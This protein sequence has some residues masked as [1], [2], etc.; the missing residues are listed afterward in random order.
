MSLALA[1][2]RRTLALGSTA[3]AALAATA[4]LAYTPAD[5]L[6]SP[7]NAR[8]H[9]LLQ[10][11]ALDQDLARLSDLKNLAS[12]QSLKREELLPKYQE[13]VQRYCE[14]GLNFPNRVAVQVMVWLFDTGQFEDALELADFL[15]EQG[16][17]MPERFKRRDIQTFVADA[18][19]EWAYAEYNAKRSPEPYLSDLLPRVDG[20]WNLT[21]QIPSKYHK[22]IG[23]RAMEAE[24][25]ETALKHLE[26]STQLYA[27]A[28]NDTRIKKVRKALAKQAA[29]TPASE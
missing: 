23:M 3:V 28:G 24:Q 6:S 4:G 29:A 17:E 10:E 22:L 27:Q 1:H 12:K 9:L 2:K 7:A 20:E 13:Y 18:V 8:K 15:M 26:R 11:A 21:E 14:S 5:A 16:Q 25:W 19:C